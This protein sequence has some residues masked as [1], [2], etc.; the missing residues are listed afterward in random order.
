MEIVVILYA[1][2]VIRRRYRVSHGVV[3]PGVDLRLQDKAIKGEL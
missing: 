3:R 2:K 1:I